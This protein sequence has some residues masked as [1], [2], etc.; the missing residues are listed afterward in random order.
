[1]LVAGGSRSRAP[2]DP[3]RYCTMESPCLHGCHAML[4]LHNSTTPPRL[5]KT[6]NNEDR[7]RLARLRLYRVPSSRAARP[8]S[9]YSATSC[10]RTD[11]APAPVRPQ[12]PTTT[13]PIP[14][15]P[16]RARQGEALYLPSNP[17]RPEQQQRAA[18]ADVLLLPLPLLPLPFEPLRAEGTSTEKSLTQSAKNPLNH[19]MH[20]RN[21]TSG[22][23]TIEGCT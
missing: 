17:S 19:Q 16:P 8:C 22:L 18:Q 10:P 3:A 23:L 9:P 14:T 20:G 11:A 5:G 13:P 2:R 7:K 1:M 12:S 21:H 4:S 6:G 15:T